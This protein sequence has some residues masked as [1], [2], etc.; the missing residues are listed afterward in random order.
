[1][2]KKFL[3]LCITV[4]MVIFITIPLYAV[5]EGWGE[6]WSD[7]VELAMATQLSPALEVLK[8][9]QGNFLVFWVTQD[10][11]LSL[12]YLLIDQQGKVLL[13]KEGVI[14]SSGLKNQ[15]YFPFLTDDDRIVIFYCAKQD[16]GIELR[17]LES[18]I[19]EEPDFEK[20]LATYDR[21]LHN[22]K[23]VRDSQDN[24]HIF[25]SN[26]SKMRM[27]S[28]YSKLSKDFQFIF[29][30][31]PISDGNGTSFIG[32]CSIDSQDRI[33][34]LN[35]VNLH[36]FG[37]FGGAKWELYYLVFDEQ[38]QQMMET[39]F[40]GKSMEYISNV[41]PEIVID[42]KDQ[43]Y[44]FWTKI[45]KV[46]FFIKDYGV[47]YTLFDANLER[48]F[49]EVQI[50]EHG[51]FYAMLFPPH[52]VVDDENQLHLVYAD[53][54]NVPMNFYYL[55]VK[56]DQI[57]KPKQFL[58]VNKTVHWLPNLQFDSDQ[59]KHLFFLEI[60]KEGKSVLNYMNTRFPAKVTYWNRIG[61]D[62][63]ALLTSAIYRISRNFFV[64]LIGILL[65]GAS[66]LISALVLMFYEKHFGKKSVKFKALLMIIVIV[67]V[68]LTPLDPS[69]VG[70]SELFKWI[71]VG[72]ATILML[73]L[74]SILEK[75]H[76]MKNFM[77]YLLFASIWIFIYTFL[78]LIPAVGKLAGKI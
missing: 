75:K 50:S 21:S 77:S 27:Q 53:G 62:E 25:F 64:A 72:V 1:M 30:D 71:I 26:V 47:F 48:K 42:Q 8:D 2:K 36:G 57:I 14:T 70:T 10:V 15:G 78:M 46:G 33:H 37:N 60:V 20:V 23:G 76:I 34:L 58:T 61:L 31:K 54:I 35:N 66:I 69:V 7:Y 41:S 29:A 45:A 22:L 44:V 39:T 56:E 65:G 63:D 55:M 38:G 13:Q 6:G 28:H 40:I 59:N 16:Q 51:D 9:S 17:V 19:G 11:E 5:P 18:A 74:V 68:Q 32:S 49:E 52:T 67:L 12:N 3:L 4:V 24:F 73:I 43:I